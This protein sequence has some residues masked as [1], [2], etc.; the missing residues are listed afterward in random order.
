MLLVVS[1]GKSAQHKTYTV[2]REKKISKGELWRS[3]EVRR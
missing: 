2:R 1:L 3:M